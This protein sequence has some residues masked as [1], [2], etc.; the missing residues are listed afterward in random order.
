MSA[1]GPSVATPFASFGD[2]AQTSRQS[3]MSDQSKPTGTTAA[4]VGPLHHRIVEADLLGACQSSGRGGSAPRSSFASASAASTA[5]RVAPA[6]SRRSRRAPHS[7]R[8][9]EHPGVPQAALGDQ[10]RGPPRRRAS[11]RRPLPAAPRRRARRPGGCSRSPR[12]AASARGRGRR[13]RPSA[14]AS[15]AVAAASAKAQRSGIR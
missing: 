7:A 10:R 9:T 4:C 1:V 2:S 5:T 11:R 8:K 3:P 14:A 6:R 15:A 13:D 12:P